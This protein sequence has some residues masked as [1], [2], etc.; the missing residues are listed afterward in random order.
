M[1]MSNLGNVEKCIKYHRMEMPNPSTKCYNFLSCVFSPLTSA[2]VCEK[3]S[4]WLRKEKSCLY[5]CE[6]ARKHICVTDRH[7]MTLAVKVALNTNTTN[8][9]NVTKYIRI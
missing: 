5:W 2:E 6:K 1:Q 8:Q 4:R 3:S 9:Q 7:H